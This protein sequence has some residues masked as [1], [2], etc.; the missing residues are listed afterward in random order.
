MHPPWAVRLSPVLGPS[1]ALTRPSHAGWLDH[2][3]PLGKKQTELPNCGRSQEAT[4]YN[5]FGMA[6]V[7]VTTRI[8]TCLVRDSYQPS[9]ST[10]TGRGPY[11]NNIHLFS[12]D[13]NGSTFCKNSRLKTLPTCDWAIFEKISKIFNFFLRRLL[14]RVVDLALNQAA[15]P[16]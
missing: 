16:W 13:K 12:L 3:D 8:I 9:L 5:I 11:P 7:T 1:P 15:K 2:W 10:V 4:M 6:P 14:D